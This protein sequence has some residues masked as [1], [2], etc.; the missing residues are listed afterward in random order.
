MQTFSS[1]DLSAEIYLAVFFLLR[2]DMLLKDFLYL[3]MT[4]MVM[5]TSAP[6]LLWLYLLLYRASIKVSERDVCEVR[7]IAEIITG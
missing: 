6:R 7:A 5:S 2:K 4:F 3:D 1:A